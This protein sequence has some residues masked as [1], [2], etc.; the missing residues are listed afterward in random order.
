MFHRRAAPPHSPVR[1]PPSARTCCSFLR[2]PGFALSGRSRQPLSVAFPS[3]WTTS[4]TL[5]YCLHLL[6]PRAGSP[7][8][9]HRVPPTALTSSFG[10]LRP[11]L[12]LLGLSGGFQGAA[13]GNDCNTNGKALHIVDAGDVL[14]MHLQYTQC[15]SSCTFQFEGASRL[16]QCLSDDRSPGSRVFGVVFWLPCSLF[17]LA[18]WA[19]PCFRL[20]LC[21]GPLG[22]LSLFFFCI[23]LSRVVRRSATVCTDQV[24][25]ASLCMV[26]F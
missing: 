15:L 8:R 17:R 26:Q 16:H 23:F 13:K 24:L 6:W 22:L 3:S 5:R 9:R 11:G 21:C 7:L 14:H 20:W 19:F 18:C 12:R 25:D 4:L 1:A 10:T 2:P